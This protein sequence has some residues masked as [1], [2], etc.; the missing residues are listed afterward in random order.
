VKVL[1]EAGADVSLLNDKEETA[2]MLAEKD[3]LKVKTVELLLQHKN[4]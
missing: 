1:L 4:N 3:N 2:L